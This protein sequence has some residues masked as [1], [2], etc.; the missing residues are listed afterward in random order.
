M[1]KKSLFL[2]NMSDPDNPIELAFQQ[3]YGN[4]VDYKWYAMFRILVAYPAT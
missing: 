4:I 2:Y 1:G 3:K